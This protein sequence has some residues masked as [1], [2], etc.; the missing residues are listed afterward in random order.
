MDRELLPRLCVSSREH[1]S[2]LRIRFILISYSADEPKV[3][4]NHK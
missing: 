1:S 3:L 4:S 2:A